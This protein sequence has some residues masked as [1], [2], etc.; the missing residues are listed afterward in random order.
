MPLELFRLEGVLHEDDKKD[1]VIRCVGGYAE[2]EHLHIPPS[3]LV[4]PR[5]ASGDTERQ[6][7]AVVC[8]RGSVLPASVQMSCQMTLTGHIQSFEYVRGA[9]PATKLWVDGSV[10]V[11]VPSELPL[12]REMPVVLAFFWDG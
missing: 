1:L 7:G 2:V 8:F 4:L 11:L 5:V 10:C 9:C 3:L 6:Q 12:E